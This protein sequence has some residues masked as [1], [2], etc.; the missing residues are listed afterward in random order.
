MAYN[1]PT[2]KKVQ[3]QDT[4]RYFMEQQLKDSSEVTARDDSVS[5]FGE[6]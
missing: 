6:D 3:R 1:I 4:T 2:Q 5:S